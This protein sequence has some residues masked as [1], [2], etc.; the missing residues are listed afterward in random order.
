MGIEFVDPDEGTKT[1]V[2]KMVDKL[3]ADLARA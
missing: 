1:L 2:G 3:S